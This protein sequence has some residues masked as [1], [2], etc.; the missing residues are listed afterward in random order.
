MRF[1]SATV[2]GSGSVGP[3]ARADS[4]PTGTSLTASVTFVAS[5][6]AAASRPPLI[7]EMCFRTVL[8][9]SIGAPQVTSALYV[10]WTSSKVCAESRGSSTSADPP[11]E[12]R[13][14]SEERRV[15]KGGR[16]RRWPDE[17]DG[18]RH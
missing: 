15:G 4:F 8:I 13:K 6:A 7:A 16:A 17:D 18:Q 1:A 11:P 3:D 14:R 12:R 9:A 5:C 2:V 10:C